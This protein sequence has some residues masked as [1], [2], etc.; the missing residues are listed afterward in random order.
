MLPDMFGAA[1]N[2][3]VMRVFKKCSV[4]QRI[5]FTI[6]IYRF[7]KP[8]SHLIIL[9]QRIYN[10]SFWMTGLFMKVLYL[11]VIHLCNFHGLYTFVFFK[12]C[13]IATT[14]II[15]FYAYMSHNEVRPGPHHTIIFDVP[16]TNVGNGYNHFSGIF[17]V[18]SSGVY[19]F[20]WTIADSPQGFIFSELIVNSD[21]IGGILTQTLTDDDRIS[22]TGLVVKEVEAGNVV[23]VRTSPTGGIQGNIQSLSP[24]QRTSFSGW[25]LA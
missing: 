19:V 11:Y 8:Y 3:M 7:S 24:A 2:M 10:G 1:T 23:Y 13:H 4:F 16:I 6:L 17:S 12:T 15:A 9:F 22:T 25:R 5:L 20:S 21:V 18:P 14:G